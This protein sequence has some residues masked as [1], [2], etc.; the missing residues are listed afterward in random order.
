MAVRDD[1]RKHFEGFMKPSAAFKPL[2]D[3]LKPLP[4][5]ELLQCLDEYFKIFG[6]Y[7][8]TNVRSLLVFHRLVVAAL[9]RGDV[10]FALRVEILC[11]TKGK[12]WH[13]RHEALSAKQQQVIAVTVARLRR[14]LSPNQRLF[15]KLFDR[16]MNGDGEAQ[17]EIEQFTT[18][19][20]QGNHYGPLQDCL[21]LYLEVSQGYKDGDSRRS[22]MIFFGLS[23]AAITASPA[24]FAAT[25]Q[26]RAKQEGDIWKTR[27]DAL[28]DR[29]RPFIDDDLKKKM[30]IDKDVEHKGKT[31][32]VPTG[33]YRPGAVDADNAT[34]GE[35]DYVRPTTAAQK[36]FAAIYRDLMRH[37]DRKR[38]MLFEDF[39]RRRSF[40]DLRECV[41]FFLQ[42][43][44]APNASTD[45]QSL[46]IFFGLLSTTIAKGDAYYAY[47]VETLVAKAGTPWAARFVELSDYQKGV[48]RKDIQSKRANARFLDELK[49]AYY[50]Q[51]GKDPDAKS[52]Q[53]FEPVHNPEQME[54]LSTALSALEIAANV[55]DI[56][57]FTKAFDAYSN[58]LRSQK[59]RLLL[60]AMIKRAR[61]RSQIPVELRYLLHLY[62][63]GLLHQRL[64]S[65][66][67]LEYLKGFSEEERDYLITPDERAGRYFNDFA[68]HLEHVTRQKLGDAG[69]AETCKAQG[70][71]HLFAWKRHMRLV[72]M[73]DGAMVRA[74]NEAAWAKQPDAIRNVKIP[75]SG[76]LGGGT[77]RINET[78]GDNVFVIWWDARDTVYMQVNGCGDV[79]FEMSLTAFSELW[80]TKSFY[81]EV[82]KGTKHLLV[83]I[84]IIFEIL[85]YLPDLMTGGVTGLVK[86]IVF[87][88]VFEKSVTALGLDPTVAQI[89]FAGFGLA[90]HVGAPKQH[91]GAVEPD[92]SAIQQRSS[93][94]MTG[95]PG[96]GDKAIDV[97][98]KSDSL[99]AGGGRRMDG[100]GG[101]GGT[102]VGGGGGG[103]GGGSG[104]VPPA[105]P[106][107]DMRG[108]RVGE[109]H[110]I[111]G[112]DTPGVGTPKT[113]RVLDR[114][115]AGDVLETGTRIRGQGDTPAMTGI[116]ELHAAERYVQDLRTGVT[117][118][119]K[120]VDQTE[121]SLASIND[122]L[123]VATKPDL[124]D[125]LKDRQ[126]RLQEVLA[127]EKAALAKLD[128]ELAA[129]QKSAQGL[130]SKV[131][132]EF[133]LPDQ[134]TKFR[135]GAVEVDSW[136][137]SAYV[138]TTDDRGKLQ[139][140][141]NDQPQGDLS[142]ALLEGGSLVPAKGGKMPFLEQNPQIIELAHVL[143]RR[144]GG[145]DVY[146]VMSKARNQEFGRRLERTGGVF[147]DDVIVI[148]GIAIDR[149][150]ALELVK[151]GRLRAE[152]V[153]KAPV[154]RLVK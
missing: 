69:V 21:H 65:W 103:T 8:A 132:G 52:L 114:G 63:V 137:P 26:A 47:K 135:S 104:T 16:H 128:L 115:I 139:R 73:Q 59:D 55:R 40:Q 86:S 77:V 88:I 11:R 48:L 131:L 54:L 102:G 24:D 4:F 67:V 127:Q 143:S 60:L 6:T 42:S 23:H 22:V 10:Y 36:E 129:A 94:R 150:T 133:N 105:A 53:A 70:A 122:Q 62:G 98:L 146:I 66:H 75:V 121:H 141:L 2:E 148:Q 7:G 29:Q 28:D 154:I 111:R 3:F 80:F 49:F 96:H 134:P 117:K 151:T 89:A 79:V 64:I 106:D 13:E 83:L 27:Y 50:A 41:I 35:H 58:L 20:M 87:D 136:H 120:A 140:L 145:R 37:R 76:R 45:E 144:E 74:L 130:G 18:K 34:P 119:S 97:P 30:T 84:P 44:E 38:T 43:S 25:Y 116:D 95:N 9:E 153:N 152:V 31:Y 126:R 90:A 51:H 17:K 78:L 142:K 46:T 100:N 91:V 56:E 101:G 112:N 113:E 99:T 124:V 110:M 108:V 15:L 81:G 138:G 147:K 57:S 33:T 14:S 109:G 149:I 82:Y 93:A 32:R 1:F 68:V 123:E 61:E 85:G 19:L 125:A 118:A 72:P 39:L 12:V 71:L 107:I 5:R 92:F